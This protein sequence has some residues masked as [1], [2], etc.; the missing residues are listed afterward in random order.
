MT[1]AR[2]QTLGYDQLPNSEKIKADSIVPATY[3]DT[4][5]LASEGQIDIAVF[6]L[7]I[8]DTFAR[9]FDAVVD[10]VADDVHQRIDD[11]VQNFTVDQHIVAGNAQPCILTGRSASLTHATLQPGHHGGDRH[12]ARGEHDLVELGADLFVLDYQSVEAVQLRAQQIGELSGVGK[13]LGKGVGGAVKLA[14]LVELQWIE[15]LLLHARNGQQC[16]A[17]RGHPAQLDKILQRRQALLHEHVLFGKCSGLH[18]TLLLSA[19]NLDDGCCHLTGETQQ[20]VDSVHRHAQSGSFR[21]K[22]R[23][24]GN[25]LCR[26]RRKRQTGQGRGTH[27]CRHIRLRRRRRR[28][29][30]RRQLD[31]VRAGLG[32]IRHSNRV[33]FR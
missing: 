22:V 32:G 7:T 5:A 4:L 30:G 12:Q 27:R 28:Q 23:L 16:A 31:G 24:G 8:G 25:G 29:C 19:L 3:D 6:V 20:I 10:G 21:A 9:A 14:V 13:R 2:N 11:T 26:R 33:G 17:G 15:I 1:I 18:Q